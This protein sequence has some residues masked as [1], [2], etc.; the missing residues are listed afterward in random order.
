MQ[1]GRHD[2]SHTYKFDFFFTC[3]KSGDW[4]HRDDTGD[5]KKN[6]PPCHCLALC[7]VPVQP[8][9]QQ[10]SVSFSQVTASKAAP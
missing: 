5:K 8:A 3:L 6:D 10:L 2:Y 4:I 1:A 7:D 9:A